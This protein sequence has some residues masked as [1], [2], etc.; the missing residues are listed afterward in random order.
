MLFGNIYDEVKYLNFTRVDDIYTIKDGNYRYCQ[1]KYLIQDFDV[2]T[3]FNWISKI[4]HDMYLQYLL[5]QEKGKISNEYIIVS[6]RTNY[7]WDILQRKNITPEE[8]KTLQEQ[9]EGVWKKDSGKFF[10][11][12]FKHIQKKHIEIVDIINEDFGEEWANPSEVKIEETR[13]LNI[14]NIVFNYEYFMSFL[15]KV[16]FDPKDY[17]KINDEIKSRIICA[18]SQQIDYEGAVYIL[19]KSTDGIKLYWCLLDYIIN[20]EYGRNITRNN[21]IKQLIRVGILSI[22]KQ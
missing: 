13:K 6:P 11:R 5:D 8:W 1:C 19:D 22:I 20:E 12:I 17:V 14:K 18:K 9:M 15:Q 21:L 16:E 10:E 2:N 3:E 7:F 4:L